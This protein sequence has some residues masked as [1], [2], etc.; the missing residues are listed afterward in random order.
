LIP[1]EIPNP[2]PTHT[3][4]LVKL[5]GIMIIVLYDLRQPNTTLTSK[6]EL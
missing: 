1:K 5:N 3:K 6:N 2:I 4:H